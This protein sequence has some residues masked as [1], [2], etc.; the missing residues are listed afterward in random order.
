[1][2]RSGRGRDGM[3]T[4]ARPIPAP[5]RDERFSQLCQATFDAV[6]VHVDG[7]IVEV[8]AAFTSTFGYAA[9]EALRLTVPDL[10][11]MEQRRAVADRVRR[12]LD[13]SFKLIG[14]TK[15]G[16]RRYLEAA[17]RPIAWGDSGA[18]VMVVRDVT[19]R[20]LA[21][22]QVG[23]MAYQYAADLTVVSEVARRLP[24]TADAAGTR[25]AI[26]QA[27]LEVCDGMAA[28]LME[29]DADGRELVATAVAGAHNL[30]L[31]VALD[32]PTAVTAQVFSSGEPFFIPDLASHPNVPARLTEESGAS[33]ALWQ[34]VL[35]DGA[36]AAVLLVA[37]DRAVAHLSDRAAAVVGLFA[38]EA[39]VAIERADVL[40]KLDRLN[41]AL[42]EQV[43]ALRESD[44]IKSDFVSSVSHELRTP[45]ASILG[46]LDVLAEGEVGEL[47]AEQREFLEIVDHNARRLLNLISDLLTL[48]GLESGGIVVKPVPTDLRELVET[49]L[50]DQAPMI[51]SRSQKLDADLPA[52]PVIA[53]VD[54]ERIGQVLANLISNASKFTPDGGR[55]RVGLAGVGGRALVTVAD[56]GIGISAPDLT[57]LFERFFRATSATDQA[58]P[59]TGLGLAICKGIVDAHGGSLDVAS[60]LGQGTCVTLSL[61]LTPPSTE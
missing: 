52:E 61:P 9:D 20:T 26:C 54:P 55:L 13:T 18:R 17:S 58:I 46:Y 38:A 10:A 60:Q 36:V 16:H 59:G 35:R 42:A 4:Q 30:P 11:A 40:A 5:P 49:H 1:M 14:V 31:K 34:P 27:A 50:A 21:E 53:V 39:A 37:W 48:S 28:V 12:G 45:L 2:R 15:Y 44:R 32:D 23:V 25:R 3:P 22:E 43:E 51:G 6:L 19:E 29:P 24:R 47:T 56:A 57:R 7:R 33:S 8:N 41:H